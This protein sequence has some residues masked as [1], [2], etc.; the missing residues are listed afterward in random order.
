LIDPLAWI[1]VATAI[2]LNNGFGIRRGQILNQLVLE[3][4]QREGSIFPLPLIFIADSCADNDGI[5]LG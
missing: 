4:R 5:I 1:E 3:F 2:K